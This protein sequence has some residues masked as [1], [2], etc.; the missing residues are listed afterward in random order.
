MI[1]FL[2][3]ESWPSIATLAARFSNTQISAEAIQ[4]HQDINLSV[5]M[6]THINVQ[7]MLADLNLVKRCRLLS[8]HSIL[9]PEQLT[10]N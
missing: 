4:Q 7:L 1:H 5:Y 2:S 6:S 10:L 9:W 8:I 3:G